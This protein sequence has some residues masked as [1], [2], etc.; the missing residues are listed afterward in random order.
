MKQIFTRT[1]LKA[2][3]ILSFLNSWG[4][5]QANAPLEFERNLTEVV[6]EISERYQVII[7]YDVSTV[8]GIKVDIQAKELPSDFESAL[9]MIMQ[10]TNLEYKSID[11]KYYVIYRDDLRGR[12]DI[13]KLER[14]M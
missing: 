10:Q 1:S 11:S 13:R 14:K 12:R 2:F 3:L 8:D 5:A 6:S 9:E 4:I 7:T